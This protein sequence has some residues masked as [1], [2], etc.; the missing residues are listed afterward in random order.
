MALVFA[1]VLSLLI[2]EDVMPRRKPAS[3]QPDPATA[4]LLQTLNP[5]AAGIDI[6]ATELWVCVPPSAVASPSAP[7][8]PAILPPPVRRFGGFTADLHTNCCLVASVPGDDGGHGIDGRVLDPA[9]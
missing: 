8:A 2:L 9:L 6:G 3:S 4:A 7:S 5:H 1:V